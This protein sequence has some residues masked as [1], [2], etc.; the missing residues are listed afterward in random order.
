MTQGTIQRLRERRVIS[1][2]LRPRAHAASG[3]ASMAGRGGA[4]QRH[5]VICRAARFRGS[6]RSSGRSHFPD[7]RNSVCKV[8]PVPRAA[9]CSLTGCEQSLPREGV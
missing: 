1:H 4:E 7:R 2:R 5:P 9:E 6:G 3:E 8:P